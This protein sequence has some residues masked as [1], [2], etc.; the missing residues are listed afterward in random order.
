MSQIQAGIKASAA[1]YGS[2]SVSA[3][4]QE[5]RATV[6]SNSEC[7]VFGSGGEELKL[8]ALST[9]DEDL[10][11]QWLLTVRDNPQVIAFDAVGIWTLIDDDAKADAL[12]EAYREETVFTPIRAVYNLDD[13]IHFFEDFQYYT[14]DIEKAETS[15][16][17]RIQDRWPEL[18]DLGFERVDAAFLGKYLR[19]ETGEDLSRKLFLFNR[20]TYVRWDAD[21]HAA[22]PGYPKLICEGWPG[23]TFNRI[24]TVVNVT[25]DAV[26]F[27]SGNQYIRFNTLTNHADDGYPDAV[28]RRW[29]GVTFDR[30]DAGTY[31]GNGK[32]Y[33]FRDNQFTRYDTVTWRSDAGYPKAIAS[34]YVEDWKF[35]D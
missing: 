22:D 7:T 31:W 20:D 27:F 3:K 23:V 30:I 8:A 4:E 15:L 13:R 14:Y 19:S 24:D 9:L 10:Y 35:F 16:P 29:T 5:D 33:F 1:A 12:M 17:E 11:N 28:S 6:R 2:A 32:V 34:H 21:R 26:Y 25:P 18:F